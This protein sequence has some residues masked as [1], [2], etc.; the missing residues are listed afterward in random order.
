LAKKRYHLHVQKVDSSSDNAFINASM[1][2]HYTDHPY[3]ALFCGIFLEEATMRMYL[4]MYDTEVGSPY[5]ED[6][7]TQ[8]EQLLDLKVIS[9]FASGALALK[10]NDERTLSSF[11]YC[12]RVCHACRHLGLAS[13]NLRAVMQQGPCTLPCI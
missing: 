9:C 3:E 5:A 12:Q 8:N 10:V 6:V 1:L 4:S 11:A 2:T 13:R 7:R